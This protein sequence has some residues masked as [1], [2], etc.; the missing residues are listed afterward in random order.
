[1]VTRRRRLF[2][3]GGDGGNHGNHGGGGHA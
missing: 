2:G 1:V 3:T